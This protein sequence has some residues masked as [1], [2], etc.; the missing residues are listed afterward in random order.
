MSGC[1]L[2]FVVPERVTSMNL[3]SLNHSSLK[4]IWNHQKVNR[5]E[6]RYNIELR[7]SSGGVLQN[8]NNISGRTEEV[9]N[10]AFNVL[11]LKFLAASLQYSLAYLLSLI[12]HCCSTKFMLIL[13]GFDCIHMK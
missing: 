5:G 10:L 4:V 11:F 13:I 6:P 2:C 3:S 9:T 1:G 8:L 12:G 7:N